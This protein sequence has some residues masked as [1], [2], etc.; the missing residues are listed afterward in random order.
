MDD[1]VRIEKAGFVCL[2]IAITAV[3]E[4]RASKYEDQAID[5][6]CEP[7]QAPHDI[8]DSVGQMGSDE[9]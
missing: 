8:D 6:D 2:C 4:H 3:K 9:G 1:I 7:E 5:Q